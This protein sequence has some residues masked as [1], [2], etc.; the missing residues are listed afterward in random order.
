[1]QQEPRSLT[2]LIVHLQA[3]LGVTTGRPLA[4]V[5]MWVAKLVIAAVMMGIRSD[6]PIWAGDKDMPR[7]RQ[8]WARRLK[9]T[10]KRQRRRDRSSENAT[11]ALAD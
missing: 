6:P 4:D 7:V 1:M 8:S 9:P 3:K 2:E 5:N 10:G 11:T